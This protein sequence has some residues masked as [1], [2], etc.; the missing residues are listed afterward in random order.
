MSPG[1]TSYYI[2]PADG[3]DTHTGLKEE[4]AWQTFA[5][6]NR[7]TLSAGDRVNIIAPGPFEETLMITGNGT[8]KAPIMVHFAPGRYDFHPTKALRRVRW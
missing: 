7:L 5:P 1:N 4:Q 3:S 2:N 6:I 8:A